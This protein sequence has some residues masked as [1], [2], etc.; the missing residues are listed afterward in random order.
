MTGIYVNTSSISLTNS[1]VRHSQYKGIHLVNS[2]SVIDNVQFI[3][4]IACCT[5][6]ADYGG[7]G[8]LVEGE[9]AE[10]IIK[11]SL[12]KGSV[13]GIR[14]MKKASPIIE[15]NN[16]E[17][18]EKAAWVGEEGYPYFSGNTAQNNDL[19]GVIMWGMINQNTAWQADLPYILTNGVIVA[20]GVVLTIDPGAIINFIDEYDTLIIAGTLKA[21]GTAENKIIFTSIR[22][23]PG[24]GSWDV[25]ALPVGD[26]E[27]L[28]LRI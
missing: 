18:N 15:N 28:V 19:D 23:N 2:S 17:G 20:E 11:N 9:T 21:L 3:D 13:T 5:Q 10:P 27:R 4:N 1:I 16:F 26:L 6:V 22:E 14:I 12:I 25:L 7:F 24:P 8:I